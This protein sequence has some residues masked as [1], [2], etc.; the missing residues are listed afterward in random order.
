MVAQR[1]HGQAPVEEAASAP[2]LVEE[3]EGEVQPSS[4]AEAG[5]CAG[6]STKISPTSMRSP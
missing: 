3:V 4:G 5:A 6:S 2:G 1:G